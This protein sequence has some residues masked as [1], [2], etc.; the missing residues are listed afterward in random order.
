MTDFE[1]IA[2]GMPQA[3]PLAGHLDLEITDPSSGS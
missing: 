3:V 1:L 2:N